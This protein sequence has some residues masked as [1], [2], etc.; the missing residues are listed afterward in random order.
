MG[1]IA[2]LEKGKGITCPFC[3]YK[4]KP[5]DFY[6][7][8]ESV[9]YMADHSVVKEERERPILVI[10]PRCKKG[11]FLENPYTRFYSLK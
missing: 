3:G 1:A 5:E 11:F 4:G 9:L 7:M 6:Y 2:R 10:C 8:Y